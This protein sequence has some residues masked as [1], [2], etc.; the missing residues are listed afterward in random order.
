ML[1]TNR[2]C[3]RRGLILVLDTDFGGAAHGTVRWVRKEGLSMEV[4]HVRRKDMKE[5]KKAGLHHAEFCGDAGMV[6]WGVYKWMMR[7]ARGQHDRARWGRR[8]RKMWNEW[9]A[10]WGI[11]RRKARFGSGAGAQQEM[12]VLDRAERDKAR[13]GIPLC[14]PLGLKG[15]RGKV[16]SATGQW[17]DVNA[18]MF[19][20]DNIPEGAGQGDKCWRCTKKAG[21]VPWLVL[22]MTAGAFPNATMRATDAKG[23]W[24]GPVLRLPKEVQEGEEAQGEVEVWWGEEK[25]GKRTGFQLGWD[26]VRGLQE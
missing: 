13:P 18:D 9:V 21:Q 1:A 22:Q 19:R 7:R 17:Y 20:R 2:T 5:Y 25:K 12:V 4:L 6:E 14:A 15:P 3:G 23:Q 8:I 10:L 26:T 11:Q 16:Q 24:W